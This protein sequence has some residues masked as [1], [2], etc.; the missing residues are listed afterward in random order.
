[1][2]RWEWEMELP[3][4]G[5]LPQISQLA[6]TAELLLDTSGCTLGAGSALLPGGQAYPP[7]PGRR[8]IA[9]GARSLAF[10]P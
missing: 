2:R 4:D 10:A 5:P 1:V 9:S 3:Q 7:L 6:A 8:Q